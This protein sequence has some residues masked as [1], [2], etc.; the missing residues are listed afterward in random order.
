MSPAAPAISPRAVE[1]TAVTPD[2]WLDGYRPPQGCWDEVLDDNRCVRPS[3]QR[4]VSSMSGFSRA[5]WA[6]QREEMARLLRDHGATYNVYSDARG[7]ARPWQLD[8]LPLVIGPEEFEEVAAGLTQRMRLLNAILDDVYGPKRLLHDGWLPPAIV[9]GNPG[10]LREACSSGGRAPRLIMLGTD[11]A[12]GPDGRWRVLAD[13]AQAPSGKGYALENRTVLS[14][15]SPGIIREC[16][17]RPLAGFFDGQREV[18]R[19]WSPSPRRAPLV[20]LLT[21]GPFNETYFEHAFKARHL[22]F[23]LVEGADLTVRDRWVYLKTLEGLRRVD[24]ILRRVDDVYCDPLELR[25]DAWLGVAGLAEACRAGHVTVANALGA[26]VVETAALFPF[27]PGLCRHLLGEELRLPQAATWW[28]GQRAE[29][30]LVFSE[31]DR[32]VIKSAFVSPRHDPVFLAQA[33]EEERRVVRARVAAAPDFFVAQEP[34]SLSTIPTWNDGRLE[35]RRLVWRAFVSAGPNGS[36]VMPGGLTRVSRDVA[37]SVVTMQYGGLSKDTWVLGHDPDSGP[38]A[39]APQV[40]VRPARPAAGVPSRQADHLFW[41]GRYAERLEH[42]VRLVRAALRRLSGE[43]TTQKSAELEVLLH[44]LWHTRKLPRRRKDPARTAEEERAE[45]AEEA[46]RPP[47]DRLRPLLV[48]STVPDAV[49]AL[50]ER[51]RFNALAARDRL[52]DDMWRLINRLDTLAEPADPEQSTPASLLDQL[53]SLILG[54]A[55]LAGMEAENMTRGHGWRFLQL[56]RR[57]ERA[58]NV[59]EICRESALSADQRP[60]F[61]PPLLEL[62]DSSMTYRRLHVAA[63]QL[64]SVMDL[65]MANETNPRSAA[66]QLHWLARQSAQLPRDVATP[67]AVQEKEAADQLLSTLSS[68]SPQALSSLPPPLAA[69][70]VVA[71]CQNLV[72]GLESYSELVTAHYF[73]HALPK[74]R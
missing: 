57:V 43:E 60:A 74:V 50:A 32:W 49:P 62:C 35:P 31:E 40:V 70:R 58:V 33:S 55:A 29:R 25:P 53:D 10:Y 6:M 41:L 16:G 34:L 59:L 39:P 68:F 22:G 3:W 48:D 27:L 37:G 52:S 67:G 26:G 61:L 73:N 64:L 63:P 9:L 13:R 1:L 71:V 45:A 8:S 46:A 4:L 12:R 19:G 7:V 21:P 17:V 23:P 47:L 51:L 54:L 38:P 20:V 30:E 11:L 69:E 42:I 24:V 44:L 72:H 15:V 56:G 65:L 18:L 66:F 36:Q 28:L 14:R 2:H 5:E